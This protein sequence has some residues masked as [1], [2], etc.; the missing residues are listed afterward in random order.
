[1]A[2]TILTLT[3]LKNIFWELI[4]DMLLL[5]ST[6]RN[7]KVRKSFSQD[8]QPGWNAGEDI[9]FFNIKTIDDIMSYTRDVLISDATPTTVNRDVGYTRVIEVQIICYGANSYDNAELIKHKLYLPE[10]QE[11]LSGYNLYMVLEVKAPMRTTEL[12][13]GQW[14]ERSDLTIRFNEQIIR[15]QEIN[16]IESVDVVQVIQG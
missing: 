12:Y 11:F 2:D 5:N 7:Y 16:C 6:E 13:N 3:E 9:T 4:S 10:F 8:G 15:E 1:M 14:W